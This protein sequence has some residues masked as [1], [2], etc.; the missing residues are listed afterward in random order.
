MPELNWYE[1]Q[2]KLQEEDLRL[3]IANELDY[4]PDE[5]KRVLNVTGLTG[6]PTEV[7][8]ADLPNIESQL[9]REEFDI[10]KYKQDAPTF[11]EFTA[12]NPLHLSAL[13]DDQKNL[14]AWERGIRATSLAN[15][16]TWAQV[17]IGHIN[18]RQADG[19]YEPDDAK[20]LEELRKLQQPHEFGVES[21]LAKLWIKNVKMSGPTLHSYKEALKYGG[22]TALGYMG[23]AG[24]AGQMGPQ[25]ALGEE[26]ITVPAAGMLGLG[27]GGRYGMSMSVY[28]LERGLARDEYL[29][30]GMSEE[31][32]TKAANAVGTANMILESISM[33]RMGKYVPGLRHVAGSTGKRL[34]ADALKRP[35]VRKVAAVAVARLGEVLGLEVI[36]EGAQEVSTILG[37]EYGQ[38][39]EGIESQM[40]WETASERVA[41]I[42]VE[43]MQGALIMSSIGPTASFVTESRQAHRAKQMEVVF[44]ALGKASEKS[45]TRTDVPKTYRAF[46]ER[47]TKDGPLES[48]QVKKERFIEYFQ[49]VGKDPDQLAAQLGVDME[50]GEVTGWLDIPLNAYAEYI[51]HT[52]HHVA[53]T[54]DLRVDDNHMTGREAE[55]WELNKPE[56]IKEMEEQ[57]AALE[58]AA[59]AQ[60]AAEEQV[61][62]EVMGEIIAASFDPTAA[63]YQAQIMRGLVN[64]ARR[65]GKEQLEIFERFWG[66]IKRQLPSALQ[67]AE[68]IDI[69]VDPL[70]DAIRA[71]EMPSETDIFG[72]SLIQF[73]KDKGGL[74]DEGGEL[75]ARDVWKEQP[76]LLR[77]EGLSIDAAAEL[78]AEAGYISQGD[79]TQLMEA[80]DRE[81]RGERVFGRDADP[82]MADRARQLDELANF[83]EAEGIDMTLPNVEIRKLLRAGETFE[84]IDMDELNDLTEL[85]MLSAYDPVMLARL[86]AMM[87]E[88]SE[89]QDFADLQFTDTMPLEGTTQ[90]VTV[91][92]SAQKDFDRAV[93]RRN[94]LKKL[95][96][97]VNG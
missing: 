34:F 36:T 67:K 22:Y 71:G 94:L 21:W 51:A 96:D 92:R 86:K 59:E 70:L 81:L 24:A 75:S 84:Q 88:V 14:S 13:K 79:E 2:K 3:R 39:A 76:F 58:E 93:K 48:L 18:A 19:I 61:V 57:I 62:S 26:L 77:K 32:A 40:D 25:A 6:L 85:V 74:Q 90:V 55:A 29:Q 89:T 33:L 16:M 82:M 27:I 10:E 4:D 35:S 47:V 65:S 53:L 50:H 8:K 49:S 97:C 38:Y 63:R 64:L 66:G 9:R 5:S 45:T 56:V 54:P 15:Q 80:L 52:E 37:G 95:M 28:D 41:D 1:Q 68:D 17:E 42:M 43:T 20:N 87:P 69:V 11:A 46:V 91:A 78:A 31:T 60:E 7:V 73:I 83:I 44:K 30:L 23:I 72:Q 12:N